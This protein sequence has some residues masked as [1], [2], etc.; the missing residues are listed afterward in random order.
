MSSNIHVI[1]GME[2][3]KW[4]TMGMYGCLVAG[5]GLWA[6]Y[7]LYAHSVTKTLLQ[8]QYVACGAI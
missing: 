1:T 3:I 7:R 5:Q 8:L 4:Q 2:I 6:R